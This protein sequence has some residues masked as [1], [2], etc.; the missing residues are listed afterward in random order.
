M[1]LHLLA[2]TTLLFAAAARPADAARA[3]DVVVVRP[4]EPAAAVSFAAALPD[5]SGHGMTLEYTLPHAAQV[6]LRLYSVAGR[7]VST[8]DAGTREAGAHRVSLAGRGPA[9]GIY[10][11]V[12]VVDGRKY[13][14]PV[15][16]R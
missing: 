11:A 3:V 5:P 13:S 12:L 14:R 4:A 16:L 1:R 10:F 15:I 7:L 2:L 8:L 6:S 9:T